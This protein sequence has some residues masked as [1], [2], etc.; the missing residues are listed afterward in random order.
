M[1]QDSLK[2]DVMW[3]H[4]KRTLPSGG[5]SVEKRSFL[6]EPLVA[7]C[8]CGT[9]GNSIEESNYSKPRKKSY[10]RMYKRMQMKET[11]K[12]TEKLDQTQVPV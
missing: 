6:E 8:S 11:E 4:L 12:V 10:F 5:H 9:K 1:I 2:D 3:K 7:I